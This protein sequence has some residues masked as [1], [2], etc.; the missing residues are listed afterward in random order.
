MSTYEISKSS[1]LSLKAEILRKQQELV[2]AKAGNEVKIKVLKK[3]TPLEIKNKGVEGRSRNDETEEE[4]DLLKQSR[5]ALEY[6]TKLY[7]QLSSGQLT[8][9]E[10]RNNRRF[11]VRFDKK[12]KSK[13]PDLP[14]SDSE[15][16]DK[17]PESEDEYYNSDSDTNDRDPGEKFVDYVDC[18][19]RTRKCMQKDL[20][21]LKSKDKELRTI[22]EEKKKKLEISMNEED[23]T[24]I[25]ISP[26]PNEIENEKIND[27]NE[28]SELLSSDM[29]RE[30]LRMQWEKEEEE[31]R[32]KSD[33][34]Y[35]D[36]L[37]S[38]ARS[39]GVGYYGFSKDEEERRKQQEALKKLRKETEEQQKKAQDLK[40]SREKLLAA[41]IKAAKDRKRA[42]LGLPPL[43]DEPETPVEP[44][45]SDEDKK[46]EEEKKQQEERERILDEARKKF[47]RP[48]DIGKEGVKEKEVMTQE[49]WVEKQRKERPEMFAPPKTYSRQNF[50]SNEKKNDMEDT[51]K[52]LRF[53]TK[54]IPKSHKNKQSRT[55]LGINP[56][57]KNVQEDTII[58]VDEDYVEI[59][60]SSPIE[61]TL[62]EDLTDSRDFEDRLLG[63]YSTISQTID[64]DYSNDSDRGRGV[65]IAPPPTFDYYGP[66]SSKIP[67]RSEQSKPLEDSIEAGLK[68]LRKQ[69]E[70]KE[71]STKHPEEMFLF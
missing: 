3:N 70:H 57:K 22:V 19:G 50:R 21:Y 49:E 47:I 48:W 7:D 6:K 52:S 10:M 31:L 35:Q 65:E 9:E 51:N 44:E 68:F 12:N 62:I 64:P 55:Q 8:E 5:S 1:L 71:K 23:N 56:F 34:H 46:K 63:D 40:L 13:V 42:R 29:R 18:F 30:M 36:I 66:T 39:H 11:L 37:F 69:V 20:D 43:E 60:Q 45:I 58:D 53:S 59:P 24:N 67:R 32:N 17:Y 26:V 33:I 25:N 16:E 41:R 2:K 61:P 4:Q 15:P 27:I 14:P 54:K 28:E 38:E